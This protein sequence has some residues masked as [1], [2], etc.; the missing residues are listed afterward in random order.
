MIY[1]QDMKTSKKTQNK[2]EKKNVK[3]NNEKE[4]YIFY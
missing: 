4:K 3:Y 1:Q 2:Y